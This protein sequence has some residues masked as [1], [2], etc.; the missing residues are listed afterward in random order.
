M[1]YHIQGSNLDKIEELVSK[2]SDKLYIGTNRTIRVEHFKTPTIDVML[3]AAEFV[4]NRTNNSI[5][6]TEDTFLIKRDDYKSIT[7]NYPPLLV[8]SSLDVSVDELLEQLL[9]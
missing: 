5:I 9:S 6:I 8:G 4:N 3:N 1:I 2:L 7:V